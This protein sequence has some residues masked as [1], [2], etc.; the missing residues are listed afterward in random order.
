MAKL[1][2]PPSCWTVRKSTPAITSQEAKVWRLDHAE[3]AGLGPG[4]VTSAPRFLLPDA[5]GAQLKAI[6]R[7]GV[8]QAA[9]IV[10][11]EFLRP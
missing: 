4:I 2:Q 9:T 7:D 5:K 8:H 6:D 1:C 3:A 10:V 11:A